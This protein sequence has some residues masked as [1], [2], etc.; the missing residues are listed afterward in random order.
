MF[1]F[2]SA[3]GLVSVCCLAAGCGDD[4]PPTT[5]ID[6]PVQVSE[7]F[8]G[9]L[10][11]HGAVQHTFLTERAGQALATLESLSPD[12]TAVVQFIFGTWNGQYCQA[13]LIKVDATTGSNLIGTASTGA[14]CVIVSDVGHLTESTTY[15]IKVQHY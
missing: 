5:P 8:T 1:R 9:T 7:T 6:V 2:I 3:L 14:F 4:P 11:V 13:I 12:G 15:S 10:D